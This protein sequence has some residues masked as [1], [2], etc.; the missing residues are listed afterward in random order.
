MQFLL[1]PERYDHQQEPGSEK[2]KKVWGAKLT[3]QKLKNISICMCDGSQPSAFYKC[4]SLVLLLYS[5]FPILPSMCRLVA[6][7]ADCGQ[8]SRCN[9]SPLYSTYTHTQ[10]QYS[11]AQNPMLS[12]PTSPGHF[13][14]LVK[15]LFLVCFNLKAIKYCLISLGNYEN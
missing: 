7:H 9:G 11:A 6:H 14:E 10:R 15:G 3:S 4:I 8:C 13:G 2:R 5:V 1:L 12:S